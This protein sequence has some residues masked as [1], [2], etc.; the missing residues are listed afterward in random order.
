M[1]QVDVDIKKTQDVR[2]II[3]SQKYGKVYFKTNEFLEELFKNID[4][5]DK[6]ILTVLGSGDQSFLCYEKQAKSVDVFDV[7]R[8]AIY[9]YYLRIW[10]IEYLNQYYPDECFDKKYIAKLLR[11]VK[12]K[13]DEEQLAYEYW[14]KYINTYFMGTHSLFYNTSGIPDVKISDL[15]NI[16][17]RTK[18]RDFNIYNVDISKPWDHD[19]K[20]DVII[21][22]NISD[23]VPRCIDDFNCYRDN[24][25]CLLNDG[26][27]VVCSKF[28]GHKIS[29]IER[30]VFKKTFVRR[31]FPKIWIHGQLESP[32]YSYKK[33]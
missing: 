23:Y 31:V 30:E 16:K 3:Y 20:Y 12:P 2:N 26:G 22:S 24:L 29:S 27:V 8:L 10:V 28:S 32:G 18:K 7:N 14:N 6:D 17:S 11:L 19:K 13:T 15:E 21:T 25:D 1:K 9:Y 33:R 5:K 4:L